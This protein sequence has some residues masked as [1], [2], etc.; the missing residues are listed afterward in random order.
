MGPWPGTALQGTQV[1]T[2]SK[3][4]KLVLQWGFWCE[5]GRWESQGQEA[6]NHLPNARAQPS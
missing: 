3:N 1:L 5:M 6:Q 2:G 4:L